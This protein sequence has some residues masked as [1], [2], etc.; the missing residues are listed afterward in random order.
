MP[1]KQFALSSSG[2]SLE[3]GRPADAEGVDWA[4]AV[5]KEARTGL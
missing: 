5:R 1:S 4:M 2:E 3:V